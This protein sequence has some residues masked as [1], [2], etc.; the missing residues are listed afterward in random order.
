M[1]LFFQ[2]DVRICS[3]EAEICRRDGTTTTCPQKLIRIIEDK[4]SKS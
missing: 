2:L 4:G 1:C 3:H